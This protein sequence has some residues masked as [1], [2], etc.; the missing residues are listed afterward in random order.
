MKKIV[1]LS[2]L[3]LI[4][5][6]LNKKKKQLGNQLYNLHSKEY[7]EELNGICTDMSL[8][9]E[10]FEDVYSEYKKISNKIVELELLKNKTNQETF[11]DLDNEKKS[12]SFALLKVKSLR[13]ILVKVESALSVKESKSRRYDGVGSQAYYKVIK[14]NFNKDDLIREKELL[15]NK[16]QDLES[17]IQHMNSKTVLNIDVL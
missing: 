3:I 6:G 15:E 10:S 4:I 2:E 7:I 16:I 13:D 1:T 14:L 8:E 12:L 11:I 17:S 9:K 5:E